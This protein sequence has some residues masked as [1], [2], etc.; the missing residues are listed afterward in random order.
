MRG[1]A[2][3][4]RMGFREVPQDSEIR[5]LRSFVKRCNIHVACMIPPLFSI[6]R[7]DVP[8]D[9]LWRVM[10]CAATFMVLVV[11]GRT[12]GVGQ[13]PPSEDEEKMTALRQTVE[14]RFSDS[15]QM[16]FDTA[17]VPGGSERQKMDL[18]LPIRAAG[19]APLP[20]VVFLHG[21]AWKYGNRK[22]VAAYAARLASRGRYVTAAVS[23]RSSS[24]ARWPAQIHDCKAAIRWLRAHAEELHLDPS[25]VGVWGASSGGHLALMLGLTAGDSELEGD[26]GEFRSESSKVLCVANFGGPSDLEVPLAPPGARPQGEDPLVAALVGGDVDRK[27]EEKEKAAR[28]KAASPIQYVKKTDVAF[29]HVHG[30]L[31]QRV[32]FAQSEKLDGALKEQ[33]VASFLIPIQ[34]AGQQIVLGTELAKRLQGF[35]DKYLYGKDSEISTE[36]IFQGGR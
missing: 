14:G 30:T 35:W 36:P 32:D 16:R 24:E 22:Q 11:L 31:D 20:V 1:G 25:R 23:Y 27:R 8:R 2:A 21:G 5:P 4:P 6:E 18:F 7:L 13:I 19:E 10:W 34:E 3:W 29:L 26:L 17:Y 28:L 15:V 9:S 12:Q 33:G